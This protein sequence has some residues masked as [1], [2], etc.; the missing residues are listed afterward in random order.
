MFDTLGG[1]IFEPGHVGSDYPNPAH[2]LRNS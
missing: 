2:L 1:P